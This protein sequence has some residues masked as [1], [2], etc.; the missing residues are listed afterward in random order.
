MIVW[1]FLAEKQQHS[2]WWEVNIITRLHSEAHCSCRN[3]KCVFFWST[4]VAFP[5]TMTH[6]LSAADACPCNRT[7]P[8]IKSAS[9]PV[10]DLKPRQ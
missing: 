9:A 3:M 8:Y 2:G 7:R 10:T 4:Q 5:N 6:L 1:I